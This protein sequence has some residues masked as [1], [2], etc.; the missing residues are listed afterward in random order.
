MLTR[1]L[2]LQDSRSDGS[3]VTV[4]TFHPLPAV[5]GVVPWK[6]KLRKGVY[7]QVSLLVLLWR[8]P[9]LWEVQK[10]TL[11]RSR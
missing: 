3:K 1:E 2:L 6:E 9:D 7:A 11:R 4:T 10:L 5:C 8:G